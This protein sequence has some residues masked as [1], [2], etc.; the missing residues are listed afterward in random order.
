MITFV[1][2]LHIIVS[3]A[4]IIIV[5]LQA[6]KGA[7]LGVVFGGG[8]SKTVFGARGAGGPLSKITI[9]AAV[10]FM[11][12]CIYLAYMSGARSK[13]S[14]MDKS[15]TSKQTNMPATQTTTKEIQIPQPQPRNVPP[16]N[17]EDTKLPPPTINETPQVPKGAKPPP[18]QL[19]PD[20]PPIEPKTPE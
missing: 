19:F 8:S 13:S 15:T 12:T 5:L 18:S 1:I 14:I 17:P 20:A 16:P 7:E 2:V 6:G 3:I 10:L 11:C 9:G 4:L